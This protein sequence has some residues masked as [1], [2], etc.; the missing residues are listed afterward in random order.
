MKMTRRS[1]NKIMNRRMASLIKTIHSNRRVNQKAKQLTQI[2]LLSLFALFSLHCGQDPEPIHLK[3]E[4]VDTPSVDKGDGSASPDKD[5]IH[6]LF[7]TTPEKAKWVSM[8]KFGGA[9]DP[10]G[11]TL[12]ADF[13]GDG[14]A[15]SAETTGNIW[16]A[17]YPELSAD[18]A[19]PI[20]MQ[21]KLLNETTDKTTTLSSDITSDDL[22]STKSDGSEK[23]HQNEHA[24]RTARYEREVSSKRANAQET[25][26][27]R[28]GSTRVAGSASVSF[29]GIA[30]AE[31][32][33]DVASSFD[34]SDRQ[35]TSSSREN[36]ERTTLFED[37]PFVNNIDRNG[38]TIK[39]DSA[40]KKARKYRKEANKEENKTLSK[41]PNAGHVRASLFIR[42]HSVNMPVRISNILCSLLFETPQGEL[43][44]VQSFRLRNDD[45]SIFSIE[46]YGASE[47]GPYVIELPGLNTA[48]VEAALLKGYTPKIYIIDYE[49][50]HVRDSNY[51]Q[52]LSSNFTGDNLRIIE[53]NAKG[54]TALLKLI[55]PRMRQIYRTVAFQTKLKS[56]TVNGKT[57]KRD[58]CNLD[59]ID[60]TSDSSIKAGV[61]MREALERL[62]CSGIDIEFEHYVYDYSGTAE[63]IIQ[64]DIAEP[65]KKKFYIYTY[66]IKSIN[67]IE[68][69]VPCE[70]NK[71]T[72]R[73]IDIASR[74][75]TIVYKNVEACHIKVAELTNEERF[76]LSSWTIF[77]NGK[78]FNN[79]EI[80]N[81]TE[82]VATPTTPSLFSFT[83]GGCSKYCRVSVIKGLESRIWVGDNYDIVYM[84]MF[85]INEKQNS[86]GVN[87]F[88]TGASISY[89]TSWDVT[90]AGYQNIDDY[91]KN[92]DNNYHNYSEIKSQYLGE[93]ALGEQ[94]EL[95]FKL[96]RT[97]FLK[98]DFTGGTDST[99]D[100]FSY[101]PDTESRKRFKIEEAIDFEVNFGVDNT[102]YNILRD[103]KDDP[104]NS[105]PEKCR[106]EDGGP[107]YHK[108][109]N[110]RD[111]IFTVC[112]TL[113][114]TYKGIDPDGAADVYLRPVLSNA[115]RNSLW[116]KKAT[117]INSF[118]GILSEGS[119]KG[120]EII[121]VSNFSGVPKSGDMIQIG[122][123][124]YSIS[125]DSDDVPTKLKGVYTI[126]LESATT[127]PYPQGSQVSV[128]AGFSESPFIL[129]LGGAMK[130]NY[131]TRWNELP[132]RRAKDMLILPAYRNNLSVN[133][134]TA[135]GVPSSSSYFAP[136][137]CLGYDPEHI[138]ANWL[139]NRGFA[140]NWSD[141]SR[142]ISLGPTDPLSVLLGEK[143]NVFARLRF[144]LRIEL[145][146]LALGGF[147]NCYV[148]TA[149]TAKKVKCW[150]GNGFGR[151]GDGT[152]TSR[153]EP[154]PV[155]GLTNV[156]QIS[157]GN[158]HSCALLADDTLKCWG[159]NLSGQLGDGTLVSRS[160]PVA[161]KYDNSGTL[162]P[163]GGV[164]IV[165]VASVHVTV[166]QA[167]SCAALSAGGI[168]C[169][170]RNGS[171]QLGDG[172][173]TDRRTAVDVSGLK[174]SQI[175][176][177]SL[178]SNHTC[179]LILGGNVKCWGY[180]YSGQLGNGLSGSSI[181]VPVDVSGISNAVKVEA[182][183]RHSCALL[184]DGRVKCWGI[185]GS[186]QLGN[187]SDQASFVPVLVSGLSDVIDLATSLSTTC[188][189]LR[190]GRVKCWGRNHLAAIRR[191]SLNNN[192][193][194]KVP[195]DVKG[196][197]EPAV[198][199]LAGDYH[200]CA[201]L[202][203][204]RIKCWGLNTYAQLGS[205]EFPGNFDG[206]TSLSA[207]KTGIPRVLD[208]ISNNGDDLDL[209]V[210]DEKRLTNMPKTYFFTSPLIERDYSVTARIRF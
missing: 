141:A 172:T 203:S 117:E 111:Q 87:P 154:V 102:W 108:I 73:G 55:G 1:E 93:A 76:S 15:N 13:D 85:D 62:K 46:V 148:T 63:E 52:A 24:V 50:S 196:L 159:N 123:A 49:M 81:D 121:K 70:K 183:W 114:K 26:R 20:T 29:L 125:G 169:W 207:N 175:T 44:P 199:I 179:V 101:S 57:V 98:P 83:G 168:K 143:S 69:N 177:I 68:N 195:V 208:V 165:D 31:Y 4:K 86:F 97:H 171:G 113:P 150:G 67:G 166:N 45:Y 126:T 34:R 99:Y 88:E 72:V 40:S 71:L 144:P 131:A 92:K 90:K 17:D 105:F 137:N 167:H 21:I 53:E 182:G 103:V 193:H 112:F 16:V 155:L 37:K 6:P 186:G 191:F 162:S 51:K 184:K 30:S 65:N 158:E 201:L 209:D 61:S 181:S 56:T 82:I 74:E 205:S 157:T 42:N 9:I 48:E 77:A 145:K 190:D 19:P 149:K 41:K 188:A 14:L 27:R 66:G 163:L 187:G 78:Y 10:V 91:L 18:I 79:K 153:R 210:L 132:G 60:T 35:A 3:A 204:G 180:N 164:S 47:F 5:T 136:T 58:V 39:S 142:H 84:S 11:T 129:Y 22:E 110:L 174:T 197:N 32:S 147:H 192:N 206:N 54:R 146:T 176:D 109:W 124:E 118:E 133:C 151:L 25:E 160:G 95:T 107:S 36:S 28:A 115:Y 122:E 7:A 130:N 127:A 200:R 194:S 178:G 104:N 198:A 64:S 23:F 202:I 138:V 89:N 185:N 100:N 120:A 96:N 2:V 156:K 80:V 59:D 94:I 106:D 173:T 161:V 128:N 43:R 12:Q 119:S 38:T 189:L 140:N 152:T 170:G 75:D 33:L 8:Q 116:P 135:N 134:I 139:G